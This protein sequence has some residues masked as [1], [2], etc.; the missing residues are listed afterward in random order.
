M[1]FQNVVLRPYTFADSPRAEV[2]LQSL[3]PPE[4]AEE[5]L[6]EAG[7]AWLL[8]QDG[9]ICGLGR[10][11]DR[12]F[13]PYLPTLE[14]SLAPSSWIDQSAELLYSFLRS[15]RPTADVWRCQILERH[16]GAPEFL[17]R[18]GFVEMRRTWMPQVR[19]D[20]LPLELFATESQAALE[21]GYQMCTLEKFAN[22]PAFM[23]ELTQLYQAAYLAT[24][25]INPPAPRSLESW[26]RIFLGDNLEP[27]LAFVA[28]KHGKIVAFSSL[29]LGESQAAE[30]Y[31]FGVAPEYAT[32]SSLL[33]AALKHS[34]FQ[35][36]RARGV[37]VLSFEIDSTNP[38]N[39]A[40][41]E[42]LPI[43]RGEAYLTF[44]TGIPRF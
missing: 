38:E 23:L 41:L 9:E 22:D 21:L 10:I 12:T 28:L 27:A 6:P 44:Q 14:L 33:N 2:F 36:A 25:Q 42:R 32:H 15:Q 43:A 7:E 30:V 31:W 29:R 18:H 4:D 26:Q 37:E 11:L 34:E 39:S 5:R 19:L 3:W 16:H 24:H 40:L 13:H 35:A 1:S 20:L 17:E 8:E